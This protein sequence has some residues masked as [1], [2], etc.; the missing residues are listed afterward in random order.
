MTNCVAGAKATVGL[1]NLSN[2]ATRSLARPV[3]ARKR[4]DSGSRSA[5]MG[6]SSSGATPPTTNTDR[7][8]EQ[9]CGEH[10]TQRTLGETPFLGECGRD[11]AD[12]LGVKAVQ[13]Q[14]RR[15]GQQ[16]FELKSA[17]RLLVDEF[18]NLHLRC[19]AALSLRNRHG[20]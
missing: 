3:S 5:S 16:Q 14:H 1:I 11:I 8:P 7:Q 13:K 15:A 4:T 2:S 9:A 18:S 6:T 12:G 10:G 19:A 17:D 20:R